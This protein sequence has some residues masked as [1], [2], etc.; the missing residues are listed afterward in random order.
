MRRHRHLP[1]IASE[2]SVMKNGLLIASFSTNLLRNVQEL[3]LL[4]MVAESKAREA[5][6]RAHAREWRT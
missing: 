4:R 1:G 3:T 2:E 5:D 6:D